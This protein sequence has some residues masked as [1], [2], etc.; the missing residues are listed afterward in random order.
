M[1]EKS[2]KRLLNKYAV[3]NG[4]DNKIGLCEI[5]DLYYCEKNQVNKPIS[6]WT[7]EGYHEQYFQKDSRSLSDEIREIIEIYF[8]KEQLYRGV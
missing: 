8:S 6:S 4:T 5:C 7:N 3:I 1:A 2:V